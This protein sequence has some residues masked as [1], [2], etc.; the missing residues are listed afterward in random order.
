[1]TEKSMPTVYQ[2]CKKHCGIVRIREDGRWIGAGCWKG[3][4]QYRSHWFVKS[5]QPTKVGKPT[6]HR[7]RKPLRGQKDI[8]FPD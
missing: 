5:L 7:T 8:P 3:G 4:E 1:M 6:A 2:V